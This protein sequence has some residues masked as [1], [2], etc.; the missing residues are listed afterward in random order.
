[1]IGPG[2]IK[3]VLPFQVATRTGR[4]R[5]VLIPAKVA[6]KFEGFVLEEVDIRINQENYTDCVNV[7]VK[8]LQNN[9]CILVTYKAYK[10]HKW[11]IKVYDRNVTEYL[12]DCSKCHY[13]NTFIHT[14]SL[15]FNTEH[16]YHPHPT[17]PPPTPDR[18]GYT[19][20]YF[21]KVLT[22]I[23]QTINQLILNVLSLKFILQS[24][25]IDIINFCS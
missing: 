4:W 1:M 13:I 17:Q 6:S 19:E 7:D 18:F 15:L 10:F 16:H 23:K 22:K 21:F 20:K 3:G 8:S 25:F 11:Y 2:I 9:Q 12:Q 14:A 24:A 5:T